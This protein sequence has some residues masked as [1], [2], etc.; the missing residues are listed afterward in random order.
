MTMREEFEAWSAKVIRKEEEY[1]FLFDVWQA[2][3]R[4]G[5]VEM[6]ERAANAVKDMPP[7]RFYIAESIRA[8]P[9]DA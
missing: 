2:A 5:R 3:Y 1:R 9:V 4:A 6:R 8:L 7:D